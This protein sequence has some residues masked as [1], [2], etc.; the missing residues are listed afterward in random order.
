MKQLTC[1]TIAAC[2]SL[3]LSLTAFG[4]PEPL[5][6]GKEMKEVAPAPPPECFDWSGFYVGA[7]GGFKHASVDNDLNPTGDWFLFPEDRI[8]VI[9]HSAHD[10]DLDGNG[11]EAGGFLGYNWQRGCWVF[12]IEGSGAGVFLRDSFDSNTFPMPTLTDKSIQ[13]AFHTNYL[14]TVGPRIGWS[15]GQFLPYFTGGVAF[16]N[17]S[18]ES[19]LHNVSGSPTGGYFS[20]DSE[21]DDNVGW[22][23][24]GGLQWA[25][26]Q[27]W[28][29]RFQ[30]EYVD[31]GSVSFDAPGTFPFT[32]FST[33]NH[34]E[35]SEHNVSFAL[36]YKF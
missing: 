6:S 25:L 18:Y 11:A 35:L 15:I 16:G 27:H 13:Q 3:A 31:L 24:G 14:A 10:A 29:V 4:G 22:F 5:P 21:D 23:V 20:A 36:M 17:I 30:Y 8:T 7:F 2:A 34:A 1:L 19:R 9:A 32:D 28:G 33:H 26:T 12:G